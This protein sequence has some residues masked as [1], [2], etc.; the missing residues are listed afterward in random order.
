MHTGH[1]FAHEL[2]LHHTVLLISS[3]VPLACTAAGARGSGGGDAAAEGLACTVSGAGGEVRKKTLSVWRAEMPMCTSMLLPQQRAVCVFG[4]M[5]GANADRP[6]L[7][8][9]HG[10][11]H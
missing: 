8:C 3:C 10:C 2:A 9:L 5:T 1:V 7:S 6:D 11:N 4:Y